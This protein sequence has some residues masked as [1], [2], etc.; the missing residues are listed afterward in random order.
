MHESKGITFRLRSVISK[1]LA[2]E[3]DEAVVGGAIVKNLDVAD[4]SEHIAADLVVVGAGARWWVGNSGVGVACYSTM[5]CLSLCS[6]PLSTGI[7]P[8]SDY[9]KDTEGIE[10]ARDGSVIVNEG[11]K[12]V[13]DIYVAGDLANFTHLKEPGGV[14]T[15]VCVAP[16]S[17][18]SAPFDTHGGALPPSLSLLHSTSSY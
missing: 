9:L 18:C 5:P 13:D 11:L 16:L 2:S 6:P 12:A 8:I 4:S 17:A 10:F 3:D 15:R 14:G 1:F 7:I